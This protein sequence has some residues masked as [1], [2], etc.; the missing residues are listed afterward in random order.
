MKQPCRKFPYEDLL[1]LPH[2]VSATRP[3]MSMADRAAQFSPF[4]ALTGYDGVLQEAAR[5]TE[6]KIDLSEDD[7]NRLNR[8][9]RYWNTHSSDEL[10]MS[11]T[12]FQPD[13]TKEG[14]FYQT[15]SGRLKQLDSVAGV[16]LLDGDRKIPLRDL[17]SLDCPVFDALDL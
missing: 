10:E 16:L 11:I 5:Q 3:R 8:R 7:L 1:P 6:E 14:G 12:Y 9:L 13:E 15:I 2:H 17:F 4:A